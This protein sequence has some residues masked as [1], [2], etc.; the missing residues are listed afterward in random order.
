MYFKAA[1]KKPLSHIVGNVK[2]KIAIIVDTIFDEA[3]PFV[4]AANTLKLCGASKIYVC[5]TH[6]LFSGDAPKQIQ[7]SWIDQVKLLN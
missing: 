2:G 6:G 5:A 4:I 7:N 1:K 3:L